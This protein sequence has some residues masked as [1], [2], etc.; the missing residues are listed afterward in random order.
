M[1]WPPRFAD[2]QARP[3]EQ[4]AAAVRVLPPVRMKAVYESDS[5]GDERPVA[6]DD[7]WH[8][9]VRGDYVILLDGTTCLQLWNAAGQLTRSEGDPLQ[10]ATGCRPVTMRDCGPGADQ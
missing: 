9:A 3:A 8:L 4:R 5:F 10:I 6:L 7:R 1:R 2:E